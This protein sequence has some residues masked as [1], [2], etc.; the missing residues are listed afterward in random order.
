MRWSGRGGAAKRFN[1]REH[2][3]QAGCAWESQTALRIN[4]VF[5]LFFVFIRVIGGSK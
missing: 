1:H 5:E 4:P 2:G 3:V